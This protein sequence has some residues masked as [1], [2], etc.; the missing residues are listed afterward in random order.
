MLE[1]H[2]L[3]F[4][5]CRLNLHSIYELLCIATTTRWTIRTICA[6]AFKHRNVINAFV[7]ASKCLKTNTFETGKICV[8]FS[9]FFVFSFKSVSFHW[10]WTLECCSKE[11]I[12]KPSQ[13]FLL[14]H[15]ILTK[16]LQSV[17]NGP[18]QIQSRL[19]VMIKR[20]S[21]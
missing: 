12:P 9:P 5:Y 18:H 19:Y 21:W 2:K 16:E 10:L 6:F 8:H 17:N 1:D 4:R 11:A 7:Q 15:S 13:Q 14:Y 3:N 20:T